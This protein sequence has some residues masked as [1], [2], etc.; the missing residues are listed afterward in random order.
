MTSSNRLTGLLLCSFV[1]LKACG[2]ATLPAEM[3]S[4]DPID[5]YNNLIALEVN[6]GHRVVSE[7]LSDPREAMLVGSAVYEGL[8]SGTLS[9]GELQS[10]SLAG[11]L[12]IETSFTN[13]PQAFEGSA[14]NFVASDGTRL[15]GQLELVDGLLDTTADPSVDYTFSASLVGAIDGGELSALDFSIRL[16]GDFYGL[17]SNLLA[18]G[19]N[20]I[21]VQQSEVLAFDGRFVASEAIQE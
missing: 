9:G 1:A 8:V 18:G 17:Q 16:E 21:V 19:A 2:T 12:T 13:G 6:L 10:R 7:P 15:N 4:N 3:N 14:R 5:Y 11:D 20:G